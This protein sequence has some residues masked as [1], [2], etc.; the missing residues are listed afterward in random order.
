M[1]RGVHGRAPCARRIDTPLEELAALR[2]LLV[3]HGASRCLDLRCE[4]VEEL[5]LSVGAPALA[6]LAW[7]VAHQ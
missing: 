2:A 1:E 7:A 3:R 6:A 4:H 5:C